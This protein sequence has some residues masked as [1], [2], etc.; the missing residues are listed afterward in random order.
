MIFIVA[1]AILIIAPMIAQPQTANQNPPV[2]AF[3]NVNLISMS[4]ERLLTGQ[5][6]LVR[7]GKIIEVGQSNRVKVPTDALRIDCRGKYLIP[8]L[9]DMHVH[10][11]FDQKDNEAFLKLFLVNGVTTVLNLFGFPMHLKMREQV[12]KREIIGP[13]IYTSGPFVNEPSYKTR[14][15]VE[16]AVIEQK[17]AGYDFLKIHGELSLPVYRHL[18]ETARRERLRVIGHAQRNL[19]MMTVLEEKQETIAHAE[20][21]LYSYLGFKRNYPTE[22]LETAIMIREISEATARA[23]TWVIPTLTVYKGIGFQ[24]EDIERALARAE[25][26]YVPARVKQGWIPA[27]NTYVRRFKKEMAATFKSRYAL[28]EKLVKGLSDARVR[29]LAGTDTPV[30][31]VVPGFSLH[32][33]LRDLVAAGLT[34]YEALK[35]ATTNAAEFLNRADAGT[36]AAGKRADMVLLDANPLVD[37]ANTSRISGVMAGGRWMARADLQRMLDEVARYAQE[38]KSEVKHESY[39]TGFFVSVLHSGKRFRPR[40]GAKRD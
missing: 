10:L 40:A 18:L 2:F 9:A 36:I 13:T 16:R 24:V 1:V 29:L 11:G 28:L 26:K 8:G 20:E 21:Y 17:K 32:D 15:D 19:G 30:P 38:E 33:E 27:N 35:T 14:E 12:A 31:S 4:S 25:L 23:E 5:T 37:I 39:D 6:V 3:I 7:D 22:S 34:P